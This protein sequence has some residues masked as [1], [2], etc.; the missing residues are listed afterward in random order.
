MDRRATPEIF[1]VVYVRNAL[2]V[3]SQLFTSF[4]TKK[5]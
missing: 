3:G 1:S 2:I 5:R 4:G